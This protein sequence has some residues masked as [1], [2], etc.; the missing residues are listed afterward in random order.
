[1]SSLGKMSSSGSSRY[2]IL[3]LVAT[4][5][6]A[7]PVFGVA[8]ILGVYFWFSFVERFN[9]GTI[10]LEAL[11]TAY[12]AALLPALIGGVS[13]AALEAARLRFALHFAL[14]AVVGYM[15]TFFGI[16]MV[17]GSSNLR[18]LV[19]AAALGVMPAYGCQALSTQV[20]RRFLLRHSS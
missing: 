2:P 13:L 3:C 11:L 16:I 4:T 15:A 9:L 18:G 17:F 6:I 1:M 8:V 14:I 20:C 10:R 19:L 12:L 7:A 5:V